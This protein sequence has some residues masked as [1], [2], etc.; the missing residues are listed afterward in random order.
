MDNETKKQ[1]VV[2]HLSEEKY[3]LPS[4]T[5]FSATFFLV[6]TGM[7]LETNNFYI[8]AATY[9]FAIAVGIFGPL[10]YVLFFREVD[11]D[12]KTFRRE[13]Y[14]IA[15]FLIMLGYINVASGLIMLIF[16]ASYFAGIT[17]LA[18]FVLVTFISYEENNN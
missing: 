2:K 18:L 3:L 6:I 12:R 7:A 5:L 16:N 9:M 8:S 13:Y 17:A 14:K 1:K 11:F 15:Y 4:L 10:S